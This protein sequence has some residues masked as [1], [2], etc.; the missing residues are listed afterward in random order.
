MISEDEVKHIAKLARLTLTENEIK[1]FS[2]QLSDIFEYVELLNS[3]DT[4][5]VEETSQVTGLQNVTEKDEITRKCDGED[6]LLCSP[7]PK[8]RKQIRVKPV[9]K[10]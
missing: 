6:L 1:T 5:G 7:L 3:V 10:M 9:I 4:Q 2:T 8:E